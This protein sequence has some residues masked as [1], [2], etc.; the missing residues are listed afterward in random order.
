MSAYRVTIM[1]DACTTHDVEA[2]SE[3]EAMD[4]AMEQVGVCLCHQC[5]DQIDLGDPI[6]VVVIENLDTGES[7]Y[8][9]DPDFEVRTLRERVA[10]LEAQ[11]AATHPQGGGK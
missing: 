5:S 1:H 10:E 11:L 3:D 6:R 4:R 8:D 9:A 7:N 2:S